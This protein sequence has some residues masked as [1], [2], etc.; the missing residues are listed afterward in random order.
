MDTFVSV[1]IQNVEKLLILIATHI[2]L[3]WLKNAEIIVEELDILPCLQ[4]DIG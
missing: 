4:I 2:R 3:N 1:S